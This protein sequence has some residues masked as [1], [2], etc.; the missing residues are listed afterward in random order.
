[1]AVLESL[2]YNDYEPKLQHRFVLEIDGIDSYIVQSAQRPSIEGARKEIDY[3]N[4]KRYVAGKYSWATMDVVFNDPIVP[5]GAQK[6]IEWF[7]QHHEFSTGVSGYK[8]DYKRPVTLKLLG[9]DGTFVERWKLV[10]AFIQSAQ[11]G[12]LNYGADDL[13]NI[14]VTISFDYATL[15]F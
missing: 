1:M 13:V 12:D 4:T 7:R 9:P 5:S 6:V 15:E 14:T 8:S 10:G 3:I 2:I 11:F